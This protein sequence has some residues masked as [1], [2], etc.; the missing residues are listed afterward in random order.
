ML[1]PRASL[2]H[3]WAVRT[4]TAGTKTPSHCWK[5]HRALGDCCVNPRTA[6]MRNGSF[7]D[8]FSG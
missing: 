5:L 6:S 7:H 1:L 2:R 4:K 8:I 3:P